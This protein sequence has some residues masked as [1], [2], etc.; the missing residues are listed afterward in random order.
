MRK[1]GRL[2]TLAAVVASM[3]LPIQSFGANAAANTVVSTSI[4]P[5]D[6]KTGQTLTTG[7]GV[8]TGHIQD[9]AIT[10]AKLA[11]GSVSS[12]KIFGQLSTSKLRVGTTVG[13]VAAGD[14]THVIGTANLAD[15]TVTSSKLAASSVGIGALATGA[16]TGT[17]LADGSVT[18]SKIAG[19]IST[20]KLNVGTSPGMVA[21]GDHS[22]DTIYQKKYSNVIVVAKSG[23]D[24]TDP[25]SAMN[26]ITNATAENTYLIKI[27]PGIY[28]IVGRDTVLEAHSYVDIEGSGKDVTV[29]RKSD[30]WTA[31]HVADVTKSELRNITIESVTG[32]MTQYAIPLIIAGPLSFQAENVNINIVFGAY[33]ADNSIGVWF[34]GGKS[35]FKNIKVTISGGDSNLFSGFWLMN[36][37]NTILENVT[38]ES[39]VNVNNFSAIHYRGSDVMVKNLKVAGV[40]F[41][42][43]TNNSLSTSIGWIGSLRFYDSELLRV[44]IGPEYSAVAVN[45]MIGDV[46]DAG[47]KFKTVNCFNQNYD[48]VSINK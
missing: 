7:N 1:V 46:V 44:V 13:T 19:P 17:A 2:L 30:G 35:T 15:G 5:A 38:V 41:T 39:L 31:M 43:A 42:N 9:A 34:A 12:S 14:H 25:M 23:G 47:G 29:L 22:H 6:G 4:A 8:K 45:S 28:N 20:S 18:D 40:D 27:M 24:F 21:S 48:V 32:G 10:A 37:G 36:S 11:K 3:C 33:G 26:S 16:V